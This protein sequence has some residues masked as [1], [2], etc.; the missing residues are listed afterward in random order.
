MA[1][2]TFRKKVISWFQKKLDEAAVPKNAHHL[3]H[4]TVLNDDDDCETSPLT[5]GPVLELC[6]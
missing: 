6:S 4:G 2:F 1:G 3:R 5:E